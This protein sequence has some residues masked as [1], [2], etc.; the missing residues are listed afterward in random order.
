ML[1]PSYAETEWT[2]HAKF[3]SNVK[4]DEVLGGLLV[5]RRYGQGDGSACSLIFPQV[6]KEGAPTLFC[7]LAQMWGR[8]GRKGKAQLSAVKHQKWNQTL[9]YKDILYREIRES[10]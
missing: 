2:P 9:L 10:F 4:T 1:W 3:G 5:V 7:Q 8:K 6:S